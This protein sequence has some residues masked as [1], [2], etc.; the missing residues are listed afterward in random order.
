MRQSADTPGESTVSMPQIRILSR[1]ET[2]VGG[3]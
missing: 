2:T 1:P 3:W